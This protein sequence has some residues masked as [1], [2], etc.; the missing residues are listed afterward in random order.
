MVEIAAYSL[1]MAPLAGALLSAGART[2]AVL[3]ATGIV[4]AGLTWISALALVGM[5]FRVML[6]TSWDVVNWMVIG[7]DI[8]VT[9]GFLVDSTSAITA[10]IIAS[11]NLAVH[12]CKSAFETAAFAHRC[13]HDVVAHLGTFSAMLAVM[14]NN[15]GMLYLGWEGV[16]LSV[17]LLVRLRGDTGAAARILVFQ[18]LAS[19]GLLSALVFML[20]QVG[21]VAFVDVFDNSAAVIMV[22]PLAVAAFARAGLWPLH[23]LLENVARLGVPVS[24]FVQSVFAVPLGLYLIV[25]SWPLLSA[26]AEGLAFPLI[27]VVA[28]GAVLMA[29]CAAFAHDPRRS[30]AYSTSSQGAVTMALAA[31]GMPAIALLQLSIHTIGKCVLLMSAGLVERAS[32]SAFELVSLGGLRNHLKTAYRF[33]FAATIALV[34]PPFAGFWVLLSFL[35]GVAAFGPTFVI[36]G[37]LIVLLTAIHLFRLLFGIFMGTNPSTVIRE[38]SSTVHPAFIA[39]LSGLVLVALWISD[40]ASPLRLLAPPRSLSSMG[41]LPELVQVESIL[42]IA[43]LVLT[44]AGCGWAWVV[45]GDSRKRAA[46]GGSLPASK[47]LRYLLDRGLLFDGLYAV[48]IVR[49]IYWLP[50]RITT[51]ADVGIELLCMRGPGT[52]IRVC[53]WLV[54]SLHDGRFAPAAAIAVLTAAAVLAAVVWLTSG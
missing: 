7:K 51:I 10:F 39:G 38:Q 43:C 49:P 12:I 14:A 15:Y 44:L 22:L 29:A 31:M 23:P 41:A 50:D 25:R 45:A 26:Q 54:G 2:D 30:L 42:G 13:R 3:R 53:G 17:W 6:E 33:F 32:S 37:G 16:A 35:D 34:S 9:V 52:G 47:P 24:A 28:T 36:L 19:L 11:T 1:V 48:V 8:A 5:T 27:G 46:T 4:S 40:Q 20:V 18:S 21:S